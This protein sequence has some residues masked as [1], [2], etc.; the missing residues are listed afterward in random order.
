MEAVA[1]AAAL[2]LENERRLVALRKA[3]ARI[4]ALV[5]AFPDLIFRMSRDGEYLEYKGNPR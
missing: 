2:A 3:Q 4:Q 1:A 5:D